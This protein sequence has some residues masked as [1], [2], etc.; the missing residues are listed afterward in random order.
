MSSDFFPVEPLRLDRCAELVRAA[1]LSWEETEF[2][3]VYAVSDG[4]ATLLVDADEDHPE[5]VATITCRASGSPELVER[6]IAAS[7]RLVS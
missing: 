4:A 3:G 7:V 5:L 1:G 2:A 6:V